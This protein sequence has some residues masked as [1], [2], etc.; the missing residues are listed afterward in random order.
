MSVQP[1]PSA[2]ESVSTDDDAQA[3]TPEQWGTRITAHLSGDWTV[4]TGMYGGNVVL[5]GPNG[6]RLQ[7]QIERGEVALSKLEI[8]GRFDNVGGH[9]PYRDLHRFE[10]NVSAAKAPER[11]AREIE[12]RLLPEYRPVLF[13]AQ[14]RKQA[15]DRCESDRATLCVE[16]ADLLDGSP[17]RFNEHAI[18]FGEHGRIRGSL[19]VNTEVKAELKVTLD[20]NTAL[21]VAAV[22]ARHRAVN[23]AARHNNST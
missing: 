1:Q 23:T 21:E 9:G 3:T 17:Q 22:I 13:D 4:G 12:Q 6:E 10:I 8:E 11:I 2:T 16:L 15:D 18:D 5:A 14:Q 20:A 7:V 19:F